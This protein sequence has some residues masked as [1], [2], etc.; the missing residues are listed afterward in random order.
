[1]EDWIHE[2][3]NISNVFYLDWYRSKLNSGYLIKQFMYHTKYRVEKEIKSCYEL[4]KT[5]YLI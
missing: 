5:S 2:D 1:M 4:F 3:Q